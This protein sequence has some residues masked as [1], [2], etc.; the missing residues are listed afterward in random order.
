VVRHPGRKWHLIDDLLTVQ[1]EMSTVR[2]RGTVQVPFSTL[3]SITWS[4]LVSARITASWDR[5]ARFGHFGVVIP[6]EPVEHRHRSLRFP[7]GFRYRAT[8][9]IKTGQLAIAGRVGGLSFRA[10]LCRRN[11]LAG[12]ISFSR[13]GDSR[14]SIGCDRAGRDEGGLCAVPHGAIPVPAARPRRYRR[15]RM[16]TTFFPR[17]VGDD[18]A[19]TSFDLP[20]RICAA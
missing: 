17:P 4:P 19:A 3:L 5:A 11:R 16:S 9:I 1:I 20:S 18:S 14:G 13:P 6:V 8:A 12:P 7:A 2:I 10:I 15:S